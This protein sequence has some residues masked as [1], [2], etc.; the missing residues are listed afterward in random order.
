VLPVADFRIGTAIG[1]SL[2][3][4]FLVLEIDAAL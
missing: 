4:L 1:L 3:R 2:S